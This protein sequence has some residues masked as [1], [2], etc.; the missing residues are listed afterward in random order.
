MLQLDVWF[1]FGC[2]FCYI[3][4]PRLDKA[5][6]ES[7]RADDIELRLHSFELDPTAST[8]P[9]DTL[10]HVAEKVAGSLA[11][12]ELMEQRVIDLAVADGLPYRPHR[13]HANSFDTHR[14]LALAQEFGQGAAFVD[15]AQR[16]LFGDAVNIYGATYLRTAGAALDLPSERVE[17]VLHGDDFAEE[18]RDDEQVARDIG[19]TGVPFTVL[20]GRLAVPGMTTV[21]GYLSAIQQA[22]S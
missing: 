17:A 6:A 10:A 18:V 14:M 2:P 11:Q 1:D 9:K 22:S 5:I 13:P 3:A 4:K 21:D 20:D 15:R 16:D 7:G 19:I 8:E 12:A